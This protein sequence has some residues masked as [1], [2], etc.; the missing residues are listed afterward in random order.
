MPRPELE[1]SL[2]A[3]KRTNRSDNLIRMACAAGLMA[4]FGDDDLADKSES[5]SALLN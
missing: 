4:E 1:L 3:S 5:L 2:S